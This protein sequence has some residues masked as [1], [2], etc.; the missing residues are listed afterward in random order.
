MLDAEDAITHC[1]FVIVVSISAETRRHIKQ[2]ACS[3]AVRVAQQ[4][5]GPPHVKWKPFRLGIVLMPL[6]GL[7]QE[8]YMVDKLAGIGVN[9]T[10][11][12]VSGALPAA[13][14]APTS[15]VALQQPS[16]PADQVNF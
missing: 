3:G 11:P 1:N 6:L 14:D 10:W 16:Q 8:Q 5:K 4:Q 12:P 2:R 9:I 13:R 7:A 15:A